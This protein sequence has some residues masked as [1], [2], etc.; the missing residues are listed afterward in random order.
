MRTHVVRSHPISFRIC[1]RMS[2][3]RRH[4]DQLTEPMPKGQSQP[5][6]KAPVVSN[7]C[8]MRLSRSRRPATLQAEQPISISL[9]AHFSDSHP[10]H[11]PKPIWF[12]P[13]KIYR[14]DSQ[15]M[16]IL[17]FQH[18]TVSWLICVSAL[19]TWFLR[20]VNACN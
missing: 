12:S 17:A 4:T 15:A 13:R 2:A 7:Q 1:S 6:Q 19:L 20:E 5:L 9:V 14:A 18:T 16:P 10:F 11:V 3:H 8:T